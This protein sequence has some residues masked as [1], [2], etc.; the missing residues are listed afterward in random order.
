MSGSRI[1]GVHWHVSVPRVWALLQIIPT[2]DINLLG[3]WVW[4]ADDGAPTGNSAHRDSLVVRVKSSYELRYDAT[5]LPPGG[6]AQFTSF[7]L[8]HNLKHAI[9][10]ERRKFASKIKYFIGTI[11]VLSALFAC[12]TKFEF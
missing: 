3:E 6:G 8:V 2:F 4:C 10:H 12:F 9:C 11:C 7:I 1:C 5:V